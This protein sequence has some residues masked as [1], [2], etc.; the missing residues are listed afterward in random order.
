[1]SIADGSADEDR[2]RQ[3]A[4]VPCSVA[5]L[6]RALETERAMSSPITLTRHDARNLAAITHAWNEDR[7]RRNAGPPLSPAD[8]LRNVLE[9]TAALVAGKDPPR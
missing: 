1:M 7:A 4:G 6:L 2:E 8:A 5:A 9:T 3:I